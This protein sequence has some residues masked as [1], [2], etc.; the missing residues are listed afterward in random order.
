MTAE[1]LKA[2]LGSSIRAHEITMACFTTEDESEAIVKIS[3][4]VGPVTLE[5]DSRPL[6]FD[7]DFK[8]LTAELLALFEALFPPQM[9][10]TCGRVHEE[11]KGACA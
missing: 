11:H 2:R 5:Y 4:H 9:C 8:R 6:P 1:E 7:E 3:L 10:G